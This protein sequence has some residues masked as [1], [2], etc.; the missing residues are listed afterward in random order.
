MEDGILVFLKNQKDI[1]KKIK[2]Y[3]HQEFYKD[4]FIDEK[5]IA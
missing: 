2:A 4:E 3:S 1:A 5:K